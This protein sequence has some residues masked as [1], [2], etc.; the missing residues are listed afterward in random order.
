MKTLLI[1]L[2]LLPLSAYADKYE[3][4]QQGLSQIL[5]AYGQLDTKASQAQTVAGISQA[6]VKISKDLTDLQ[7]EEKELREKAAK[8]EKK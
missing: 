3:D 2:M 4:I 8:C 1:A 7:K 5:M 6:L